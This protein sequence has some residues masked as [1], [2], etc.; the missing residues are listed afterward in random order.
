MRKLI[1]W[2]QIIIGFLFISVGFRTL[3]QI[4]I[5]GVEDRHGWLSLICFWGFSIG[6]MTCSSGVLLMYSKK[7]GIIGGVIAAIGISIV[8]LSTIEL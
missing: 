2:P 1:A 8:V 4:F 5:I 3:Y 7:A 6:F